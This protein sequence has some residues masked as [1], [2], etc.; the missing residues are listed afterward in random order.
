MP[1]LSR[2]TAKPTTAAICPVSLEETQRLFYIASHLNLDGTSLED[3]KL[4]LAT[5]TAELSP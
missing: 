1:C 5:A 2:R 3:W 4:R